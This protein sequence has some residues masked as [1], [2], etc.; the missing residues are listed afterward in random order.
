ML[1]FLTPERKDELPV[2]EYSAG[3]AIASARFDYDE[4]LAEPCSLSF[5]D[6]TT[7]LLV[8][9]V[10]D[11]PDEQRRLVANLPWDLVW[12]WMAIPIVVACYPV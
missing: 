3:P 5:E 1:L 12:I 2:L 8:D 11:V 4:F 9:S 6:D 7:I 10:H